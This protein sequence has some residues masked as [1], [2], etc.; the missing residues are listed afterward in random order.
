MFNKESDFMRG[1]ET[2]L[3]LRSKNGNVEDY[4]CVIPKEA[5]NSVKMAFDQIKMG[6]DTAKS[7][8]KVDPII[9][10]G[11]SLVVDFLGGL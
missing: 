9:D 7:K 6:I 1:F 10:Q 5:N 8:L 3:F 11:L 4:G 2:G